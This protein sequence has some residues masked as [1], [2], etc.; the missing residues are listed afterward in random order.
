MEPRQYQ[1]RLA[2]NGVWVK[3]NPAFGVL[4]G[5]LMT[6]LAA[7]LVW[8]YILNYRLKKNGPTIKISAKA[9]RKAQEEEPPKEAEKLEN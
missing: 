6:I 8:T 4:A 9:I 7:V 1:W 2:Q 3:L 5:I